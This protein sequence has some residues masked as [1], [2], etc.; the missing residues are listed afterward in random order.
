MRKKLR[1]TFEQ[2]FDLIAG[3]IFIALLV[4]GLYT[5]IL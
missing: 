1:M 5:G 3:A 4:F 2:Q